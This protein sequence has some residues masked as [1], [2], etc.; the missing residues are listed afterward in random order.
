[1]KYTQDELLLIWV[2]SFEEIDYEYKQQIYNLIKGIKEI[3]KT[4][5]DNK[6]DLI[7]KIGEEK[8]RTL[9][10]SANSDYLNSLNEKYYEDGITCLT[11]ESENYPEQLNYIDTPPLVLYAKGN[12]GL[13]KSDIFS[14]VGSRRSLPLSI[15]LAR[16]YSKALLDNGIT[17]CTGIAEGIDATVLQTSLENDKAVISV[18]AGGFDNLYPK[19]HTNLLNGVI[20][21]GLALSE[22]PPKVKPQPFFFPRRNRIIAGLAKGVLVVSGGIKSG[23]L[24]TAEYAGEYGKDIF[25]IPYSVG[26]KSG[27]GCNELIKRGA[28]LTDSPQDVLAYYG[29]DTKENIDTS[30]SEDEQKIIDILADGE[31]HFDKISEKTNF[32]SSKLLSLL[33][34]LEMKGKLVKNGANI[35]ALAK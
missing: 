5:E 19:S 7:R 33:S 16:E 6:I 31:M 23:T 32:D 4:L 15:N 9:I 3:K 20:E 2:D 35:Y 10:D 1:M 17:L 12:V 24:H 26:V 30:Y 18:I 25:A 34:M 8:Y 28:I 27:E 14:I 21:N 22:Y 29:L 11:A 13:L